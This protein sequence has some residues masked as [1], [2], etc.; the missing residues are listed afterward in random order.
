MLMHAANMRVQPSGPLAGPEAHPGCPEAATK[1]PHGAD[2][3]CL[4]HTLN[5]VHMLGTWWT[6]CPARTLGELQ[7][8][9]PHCEAGPCASAV[10]GAAIA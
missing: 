7:L 10:A 3:G 9:Y 8:L 2:A 5:P 4:P 1:Q 6:T